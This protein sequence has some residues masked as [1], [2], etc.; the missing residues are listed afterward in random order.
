MLLS[1]NN[2]FFNNEFD[3]V[4]K[5]PKKRILGRIKTNEKD[6]IFYTFNPWI[7]LYKL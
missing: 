5:L 3:I 4:Q 7:T 1:I 2:F 6:Y